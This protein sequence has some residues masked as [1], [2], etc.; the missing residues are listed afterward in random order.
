M[1]GD[2]MTFKI[3]FI[4][5]SVFM[6]S[7]MAHAHNAKKSVPN[8][9]INMEMYQDTYLKRDKKINNSESPQANDERAEL[10]KLGTEAVTPE[11]EQFIRAIQK[12]MGLEHINLTIR[13]MNDDAIALVGRENAFVIGGYDYLFVSQDWFNEL[14]IAERRF[15]IGHELAHL[16]MEHSQKQQ[17][18][19]QAMG[20]LVNYI[21]RTI[22]NNAEKGTWTHYGIETAKKVGLGTV[23]LLVLSMLSRSCESEADE[24]S[25][26]KLKSAQGGIA[27]FERMDNK[28]TKS[29]EQISWFITLIR[30]VV[31]C[32]ASH[33]SHDD[34][35][36]HI[37]TVHA[38][39]VNHEK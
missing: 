11:H 37:K 4:S 14:S 28:S 35:I 18:A 21:I 22:G 31:S 5:L 39:A 38:H 3:A 7:G 9:A 12:E 10:D 6:W 17:V 34:R 19:Q 20:I 27:L 15:L 13:A 33:P 30:K 36:E 23:K 29:K 24:V 16:L 26:I 32:F 8:R 2:F 25:V 1:L